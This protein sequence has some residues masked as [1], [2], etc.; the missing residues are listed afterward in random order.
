MILDLM[1]KA[2]SP[3]VVTA[4]VKNMLIT[5]MLSRRESLDD[6]WRKRKFSLR[7][8]SDTQRRGL[9]VKTFRLQSRLGWKSKHL[10]KLCTWLVLWQAPHQSV[11]K[12]SSVALRSNSRQKTRKE[13]TTKA[14]PLMAKNVQK[15]VR[16][17]QLIIF[18]S[19]VVRI[20]YRVPY[21]S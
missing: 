6:G 17:R 11:W 10:N 20:S 3:T 5:D 7:S 16:K 18:S 21:Q 9:Q 19:T 14:T 13:Y 1:E 15:H 4:L 8:A 12:Y 2:A